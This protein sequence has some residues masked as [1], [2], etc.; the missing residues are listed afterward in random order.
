MVYLLIGV[1]LILV[2]FLMKKASKPEPLQENRYE[3]YSYV[4]MEDE[5][6][7]KFGEADQPLWD[8]AE[9][10]SFLHS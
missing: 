8:L 6:E 10:H 1:I 9:R 3:I 5:D 7:E 4:V 2:F